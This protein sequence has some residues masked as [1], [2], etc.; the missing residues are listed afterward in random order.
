[1]EEHRRRA[2]NGP[3]VSCQRA[4]AT[5]AMGGSYAPSGTS[6]SC[7][8]PAALPVARSLLNTT[9]SPLRT[10]LC[11][12][13]STPRHRIPTLPRDTGTPCA[14][15]SACIAP[16]P[17]PPVPVLAAVSSCPVHHHHPDLD[18]PCPVGP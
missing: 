2:I 15:L 10:I 7:P 8:L 17:P 4:E 12:L 18:Q 11:T 14:S 5:V 13:Q 1:M 3:L 9:L 6:L 16:S